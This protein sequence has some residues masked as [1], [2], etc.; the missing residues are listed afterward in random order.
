MT[1]AIINVYF[2][3][4]VRDRIERYISLYGGSFMSDDEA[5]YVL[6]PGV[7]IIVRPE[8]ERVRSEVRGTLEALYTFF[9]RFDETNAE[10]YPT[11]DSI[12]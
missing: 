1:D 3:P 11:L 8:S 10:N 5:V 2:L 6:P 4:G 9:T 7:A 12:L